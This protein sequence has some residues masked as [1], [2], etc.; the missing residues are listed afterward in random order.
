MGE[1]R[2][3]I[4]QERASRKMIDKLM[5]DGREITDSVPIKEEV[6]EFYRTLYSAEDI[7]ANKIEF[8]LKILGVK[9][10]NDGIYVKVW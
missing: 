3:K 2:T 8:L 5:V 9:V 7:D 1:K 4:E 10:S 6:C